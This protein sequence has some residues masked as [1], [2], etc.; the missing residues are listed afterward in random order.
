MRIQ[1]EIPGLFKGHKGAIVFDF[2]NV[3]N[4]INKRWGRIE[5]VGF[6]SGGGAN[7]RDF[8]EYAGMENGKYVY[9]V[10]DQVEFYTLKQNKGES[11]W[12]VQVTARY[13]F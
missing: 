10:R 12:A 2:M 8:V 5:E 11:Q 7:S 3:G 13:E 4:M 6:F 1:Q 9:N